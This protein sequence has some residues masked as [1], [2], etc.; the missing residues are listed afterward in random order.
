MLAAGTLATTSA[1]RIR[2]CTIHGWRPI[3]VT[4]QPHS[5]AAQPAKVIAAKVRSS[6]RGSRAG[7]HRARQ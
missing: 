1:V 4:Y 5:V 3:S 2:P 6:Q 7:F